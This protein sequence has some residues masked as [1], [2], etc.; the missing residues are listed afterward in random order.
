MT[1]MCL[2]TVLPGHEQAGR[3]DRRAGRQHLV[4]RLH[5]GT[6]RRF[7]EG[8]RSAP[9]VVS[10]RCHARQDASRDAAERD[11]P[12]PPFKLSRTSAQVFEDLVDSGGAAVTGRRTYDIANAWGGNGPAPGVPVFVVTH[13]VPDHPP[14][15]ESSYT[16]VT[17]GVES[18]I[19]QAKAAA[20]DRYVSVMGASVPQQ[21]LRAGLLDEIQIHLV[22][23]L[24]V[25]GVR[26]FDHFGTDS[27]QLDTVRV[28]EA[29]GVTHLRYRVLNG[30]S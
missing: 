13:Q 18:A 24:L 12:V 20:G 28:V 2:A 3:V 6:Q 29:P 11:V 27:I 5:A 17:D 8:H 14:R 1:T 22:P 16:F 23:V 15:G 25:G 9:I 4:D 19:E 10:P 26:L 7:V 21:C 30:R